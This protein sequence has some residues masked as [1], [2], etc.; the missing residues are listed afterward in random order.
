MV[1]AASLSELRQGLGVRVKELSRKI[2]GVKQNFG[3]VEHFI[4]GHFIREILGRGLTSP[5]TLVNPP[6]RTCNNQRTC[7]ICPPR[8]ICM[9][10]SS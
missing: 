2:G 10:C 5:N 6:L 4:R 9:R 3:G 8:Q 7:I 1:Q